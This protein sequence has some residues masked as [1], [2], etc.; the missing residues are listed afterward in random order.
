MQAWNVFLNGKK[1]DTVFYQATLSS[2]Y[3][4]T[5]LIEEDDYPPEIQVYREVK[6]Q[7]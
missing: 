3:I 1:I 5:S 4:K 2:D 6:K 7:G